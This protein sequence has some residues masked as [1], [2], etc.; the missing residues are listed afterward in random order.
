MCMYIG[1]IVEKK[2]ETT[3]QSLGFRVCSV[4]FG[5]LGLASGTLALGFE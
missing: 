3:V 2:M 5:I 4:G 1:W